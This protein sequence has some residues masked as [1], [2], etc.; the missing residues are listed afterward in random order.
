[1]L[2]PVEEAG[3]AG[4]DLAARVRRAVGRLDEAEWCD[5]IAALERQCRDSGVVY[6]R[7]G[8][9]EPIRLLPVPIAALPEELAYVRAVTLALHGALTR[10]PGLYFA[11]PD[12]RALLALPPAEEDWLRTYY[13]PRVREENTVFGRHDAV[14]DFGSERWKDTFAFVEPNLGGIGGLHLVPTAERIIA[15]TVLPALRRV[16]DMLE[17]EIAQDIRGLLMQELLDHLDAAGRHGR[18]ICFLEPKYAGYGPDEQAALATYYRGHFGVEVLHADPAE[19]ELR[20]DEVCH[21]GRAID[22]AYRDY[23]VEDVLDLAAEGVDIAPM[24]ALFAQNR[25]VSTIAAEL[26]QKSCWEV[27]GDPALAARHLTPEERR[28]FRRHLPWTRVVAARRTTL[29]D[30]RTGELLDYVV[31]AREDLV[32]KPNRSYGGT[33]VCLGAAT[34]AG[35]WDALV[36]GALADPSRWVVQRRVELPVVRFPVLAPSGR[37]VE[38]PFYVVLGFA[39]S[40]Y[41]LATLVRASQSHVVNV[42]QRGGMCALMVGHP[43]GRLVL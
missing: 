19:L 22:L 31:R 36:Q 24:R 29:P 39:P 26:D 43:P 14:I 15:R 10:L 21:E 42:A 34:S 27:L 7:D 41:G 35:D 12:V 28:L 2:T 11:D 13:T 9:A 8:V 18:T 17:L 30:G 40:T 25:I 6:Q 23:S 5:I 4:R 3:R 38:E 37:V 1:M 33:G 32:L 20:G 16:D